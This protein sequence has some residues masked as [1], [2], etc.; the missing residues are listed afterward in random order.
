[1]AETRSK[2]TSRKDYPKR[3]EIYLTALDPAIGHEITVGHEIKKTRPAVILQNDITKQYGSTT[4]IAAISSKV[5]TPS[6]PNE[7]VIQPG[8]SGLQVVLDSSLGSDPHSGPSA[9][10]RGED[11]KRNL[12]HVKVKSRT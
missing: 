6:Y 11:T 10:Y 4:I 9:P 12:K 8:R 2:R 3:G 1:M 7:A 5:F